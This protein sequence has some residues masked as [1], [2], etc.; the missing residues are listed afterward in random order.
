ML[1]LHCGVNPPAGESKFCSPACRAEFARTMPESISCSNCDALADGVAQATAAGWTDIE[2][3]PEG[4]SW[5]YL[6]FCP[7]C[8]REEEREGQAV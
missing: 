2:A 3:D 5:N 6:G 7:D 4:T 1:C 8:R